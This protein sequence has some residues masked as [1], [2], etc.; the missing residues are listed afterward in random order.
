MDAVPPNEPA[1]P[2]EPPA[3]PPAA[4]DAPER[5]PLTTPLTCLL[6]MP[7][8]CWVHSDVVVSI[9]TAG[10]RVVEA[11]VKFAAGSLLCHVFNQLWCDALNTEPRP[12]LF[13]MHHADVSADPG[14]LDTLV[15]EMFHTG[16]DLL[17]CVIPIKDAR[18][19][20]STGLLDTKEGKLRRVTVR[21]LAALPETFG[22]RELVEA[23]K[24][25]GEPG[26]YVMCANTGLW[27]CKFGAWAESVCFEIHDRIEKD[28][29][30][31]F[32]ARVFSEDWLFS[33][34]LATM[35]LTVKATQKIPV[36]HYGTHAFAAGGDV[37]PW[38][39]VGHDG[40]GT[41]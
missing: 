5:E 6:G 22:E 20:T 9:P 40:W 41:L 32:V 17:S 1:P 28:A 31:A 15:E 11:K 13:A 23:W 18:G 38:G 27:V 19:V 36:I 21:E 3:T 4:S 30:G 29:D 10:D 35:G 8:N 24:L 37:P 33:S 16:A 26:R 2:P 39:R 25:E 12:N 7:S 34:T 14:W